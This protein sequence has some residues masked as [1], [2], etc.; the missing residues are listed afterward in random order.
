MSLEA[1]LL[2]LRGAPDDVVEQQ[3]GLKYRG[4][5]FYATDEC[6]A[7]ILEQARRK[8]EE[9]PDPDPIGTFMGI[10]IVPNATLRN[11][12]EIVP[13]ANHAEPADLIKMMI[14]KLYR[15]PG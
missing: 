12:D 1:L 15:L 11:V 6:W 10:P 5:G 2:K 13:L 9:P 4:R 3:T 7:M 8:R 14:D